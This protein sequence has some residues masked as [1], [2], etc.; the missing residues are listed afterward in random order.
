MTI[1]LEGAATL[2][3][4]PAIAAEVWTRRHGDS[5]MTAKELNARLVEQKKRKAELLRAR[6][7]CEVSQLDN[8]QANADF[9]NDIESIAKQIHASRAQRGTLDAFIRFS[10]L[11]WW[12]CQPRGFCLTFRSQDLAVE[13]QTFFS[14]EG[15]LGEPCSFPR[16]SYRCDSGDWPVITDIHELAAFLVAARLADRSTS[17]F[18]LDPQEE[19]CEYTAPCS[20]IAGM[21]R[22][23]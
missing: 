12:T 8:A 3:Q 9:D 2:A 20:S 5:S 16:S 15:P 6:L 4:F 17:L 14:R 10:K 19:S 13:P 21:S 1:L 7:R 23:L 11:W 18:S 22:R